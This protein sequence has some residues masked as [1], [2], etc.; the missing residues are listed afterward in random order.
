MSTTTAPMTAEEF[1]DWCGRPENA[2]R[3]FELERGRAVEMPPPGE[4]HGTVCG[5]IAYLLWSFA[6]RRGR[7]RVTTNDTGLVVERDP[8]TA[9]GADVM[10][11]D[12]SRP[13]AG[14]SR[15]YPDTIPALVVEVLS[16]TDTWSRTSRRVIQYLRHGVPLVWVVD[17]D[18]LTVTVL[19]PG[20]LQQLLDET[21]ALTGNGVL[22]D[23]SCKVADLFALPGQPPAASTEP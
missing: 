18:A 20:E 4:Q 7:G 9:R 15:R 5:W 11:F 14:V 13:L 17:P 1:F 8:D 3:R 16:P 21:D 22:P 10:F 19:R 23:F 2:D 12:D 6:V